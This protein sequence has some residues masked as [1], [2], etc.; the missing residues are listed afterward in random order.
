MLVQIHPG[1]LSNYTNITRNE[2]NKSL[3]VQSKVEHEYASK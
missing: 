3:L 1:T 2:A